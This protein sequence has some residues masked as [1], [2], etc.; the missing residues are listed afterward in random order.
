[1]RNGKRVQAGVRQGEPKGLIPSKKK[2]RMPD[3]LN[4]NSGIAIHYR[5]G[6]YK[7]STLKLKQ[8]RTAI[9]GEAM[10]KKIAKK[11]G[12]VTRESEDAV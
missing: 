6:G 1:V 11:T 12:V 4:G 5:W 8:A 2:G 10:Q 7:Q 3:G 9:C